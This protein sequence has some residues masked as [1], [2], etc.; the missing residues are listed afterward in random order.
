MVE[1]AAL[2]SVAPSMS[3]FISFCCC[4]CLIVVEVAALQ[5]VAPS[6]RVFLFLFVVVFTLLWLRWLPCS[7]LLPQYEYFNFF[8]LL[9]LLYCG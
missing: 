7:L 1:V 5:S 4:F 3:I 2:Q 8:L 9:F 6:I